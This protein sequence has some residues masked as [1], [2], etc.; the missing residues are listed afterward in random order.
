[1]NTLKMDVLPKTDC[2]TALAD[3]TKSEL[4]REP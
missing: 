1:M 2:S 3:D 4:S